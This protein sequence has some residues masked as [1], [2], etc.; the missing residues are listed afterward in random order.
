M[1]VENVCFPKNR[2]ECPALFGIKSWNLLPMKFIHHPFPTPRTLITQLFHNWWAAESPFTSFTFKGKRKQETTSRAW[3]LSDHHCVRWISVSVVR[4]LEC[5]LRWIKDLTE[6]YSLLSFPRL[7]ALRICEPVECRTDTEYKIRQHICADELHCTPTFQ[8]YICEQQRLSPSGLRGLL[9][10][11]VVAVYCKV[12][13][14]D[15]RDTVD[16]NEEDEQVQ[17]V[18]SYLLCKKICL[19]WSHYGASHYCVTLRNTT[20]NSDW[21]L[22]ALDS[23]IEWQNRQV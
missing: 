12:G 20:I 14:Q 3:F 4:E 23:M 2:D 11:I 13:A 7:G 1:E 17:I 18:T 21:K 5:S 6:L 19:K 8:Q 10:K 22:K 9:P 16:H 15:N